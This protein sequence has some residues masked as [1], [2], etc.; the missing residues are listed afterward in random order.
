MAKIYIETAGCSHNFSDSEHMAGLLK[1]AKHELVSNESDADLVLFNTCTVKT[2][3]E[4]AFFNRLK[5]IEKQNKKAVI[6][7]CIPQTDP[8]KFGK[9]SIIGTH[10]LDKITDV[11]NSTLSGQKLQLVQRNSQPPLLMP[12]V[13]QNPTVEIITINTGCLGTCTFCKTKAARG[14]LNSYSPEDIIK[15]ARQATNESVNEIWLTSQD[16]ACY[17]FD[18]NT[19]VA[20]LLNELCKIGKDFKIRLGMGNPDHFIKITD[21]VIESMKNDKVYKFLHVPLQAGNNLVLKN[22]KREYTVE[23]YKD[24]VSKFKKEFSEMTIATDIIVG[25]PGETQEQFEDTV[26]VIEE[27]RPDVVNV[28]RYWS[29]DKTPA[30]KRADHLQPEEIMNRSEKLS[31]LCKQISL[32]NKKPLIGKEL[33][34]TINEKGKENSQWKGRT[35]S[36]KQVIIN[37]DFKLGQKLKVKIIDVT[38]HDLIAEILK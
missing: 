11:V 8:E 35:D 34:I 3:T 22:M 4:H 31:K 10:Q 15:K 1:Q 23:Q 38:V 16:T 9:H 27:T 21:K 33:I 28:S 26:R 13:R 17:G 7:G 37:G 32:E 5:Q 2:P 36:Y 24:I 12:R 14:N 6:G 18:I 29:R 30:A 20:E 19:N 25:F